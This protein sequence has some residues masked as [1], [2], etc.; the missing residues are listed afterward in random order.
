MY[1]PVTAVAD[2]GANLQVRKAAA[3]LYDVTRDPNVR[4]FKTDVLHGSILF[5]NILVMRCRIIRIERRIFSLCVLVGTRQLEV[6]ATFARQAILH[7]PQ[8]LPIKRS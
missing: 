8:L 7:E 3:L 1:E 6:V 5:S 4:D 2:V